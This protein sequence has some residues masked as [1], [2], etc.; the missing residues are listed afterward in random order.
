M[1][2]TSGALTLVPQTFSQP[3][4]GLEYTD[5]GVSQAPTAAT[6]F[7]VRPGQPASSCQAGFGESEQP[8]PDSFQVFSVKARLALAPFA[9]C[10]LVPPIAATVGRSAGKL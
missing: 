7:S 6:S 4:S 9:R 5:T 8:L 2:A 10:R 1:A 3:P